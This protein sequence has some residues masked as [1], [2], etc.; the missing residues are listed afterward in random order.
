MEKCLNCNPEGLQVYQRGDCLTCG[1]RGYLGG[2]SPLDADQITSQDEAREFAQ[3]WQAW[4]AEQNL[5]MSEVLQ[6]QG[7]FEE[8]A[9]KYDL[10]EE[11][12]ENGII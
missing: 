10:T 12:E 8:L 9:A 7:V 3:N 5:F 2:M 11:F 4:Q 6:W 1:G